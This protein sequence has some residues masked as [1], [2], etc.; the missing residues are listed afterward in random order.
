MWPETNFLPQMQHEEAKCLDIP[1][2]NCYFVYKEIGI[3]LAIREN[4]LVK[5]STFNCKTERD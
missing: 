5:E 2:L 1:A 4:G 3:P